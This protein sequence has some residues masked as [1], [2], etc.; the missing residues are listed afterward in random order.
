MCIHDIAWNVGKWKIMKERLG[1]TD[2]EMKVFR[3]NPRNED[4]LSKVPALMNKTI[5]LEVVESHGCNSQHKVGDRLYFDGAGNLITKHCPNKICIYALKASAQMIFACKGG[6]EPIIQC[7]RR[8]E[9]SSYNRNAGSLSGSCK[10]TLFSPVL[11][12]NCSI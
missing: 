5:I 7:P 6:G 10:P 3:E 4:V 11:A 12:T 1:Y 2:E 9:C 8:R